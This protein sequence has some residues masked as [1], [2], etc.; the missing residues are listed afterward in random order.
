MAASNPYEEGYTACMQ[1]KPWLPAREREVR[2][3]C[4]YDAQSIKAR[5]WWSGWH[6]A[7]RD[8][9]QFVDTIGDDVT[10]PVQLAGYTQLT[11]FEAAIAVWFEE[12]RGAQ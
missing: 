4:P 12:Q 7:G 1:S 3:K 9:K 10:A 6:A 8:H 11:L 2:G 5:R